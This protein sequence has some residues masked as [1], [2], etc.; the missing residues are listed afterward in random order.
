MIIR[1]VLHLV[2]LFF[3]FVSCIYINMVALHQ[4]IGSSVIFYCLRSCNKYSIQR[5]FSIGVVIGIYIW[6]YQH[7]LDYIDLIITLNTSSINGLLYKIQLKNLKVDRN[8][9]RRFCNS[10]LLIRPK[11][12]GMIEKWGL[13]YIWR[14][15]PM[16]CMSMTKQTNWKYKYL[17]K[18]W[19]NAHTFLSEFVMKYEE[20]IAK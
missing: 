17:L 4:W 15:L 14:T 19:F 3:C 12:Y 11:T 7:M 6:K 20:S 10:K 5:N 8:K 2:V 9:W 16:T 1:R 13:K 18:S